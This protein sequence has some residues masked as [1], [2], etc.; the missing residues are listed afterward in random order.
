MFQFA[1]CTGWINATSVSP[2]PVNSMS[3]VKLEANEV[4]DYQIHFSF[5]IKEDRSWTINIMG[6]PQEPRHLPI[7]AGYFL[8]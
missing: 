7:F 5:K 1:P 4:G 3:L 6:I 2:A 8:L